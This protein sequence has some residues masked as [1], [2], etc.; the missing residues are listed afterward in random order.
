MIPDSAYQVAFSKRTAKKYPVE[1]PWL[2]SGI[3]KCL[4]VFVNETRCEG[5][6]VAK[7]QTI[8]LDL[9][10]QRSP[11]AT[12]ARILLNFLAWIISLFFRKLNLIL[13]KEIISLLF[14]EVGRECQFFQ[15]AV[16][17]SSSL[18]APM[19]KQFH[20]VVSHSLSG[21]KDNHDADGAWLALPV[22]LQG[23]RWTSRCKNSSFKFELTLLQVGPGK[24][25][26][27]HKLSSFTR[28]K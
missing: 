4:G 23:K 2:N 11:L 22:I 6:F 13:L 16:I 17:Q 21:C 7:G 12:W 8:L 27:G 18:L 19:N 24:T 28:A 9:L 14:V 15:M 20:L 1:G 10:R 3:M 5:Y 25:Y 26:P